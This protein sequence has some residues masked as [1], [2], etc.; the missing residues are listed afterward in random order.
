MGSRWRENAPLVI[1]EA[2]A[3]GCPVVAPEIGGIPELIQDGV[4]GYLFEPNN[5]ESCVSA[6]KR[7]HHNAPLKPTPPPSAQ[8]A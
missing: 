2:R 3:A 1:L 7:W 6:L 5:V 4:D 8:I